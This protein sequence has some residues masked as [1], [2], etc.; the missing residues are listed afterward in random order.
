MKNLEK[1]WKLSAPQLWEI[2]RDLMRY[3]QKCEIQDKMAGELWNGLTIEEIGEKL[4]YD[5][6]IDAYF[7]KYDF[8]MV[9]EEFFDYDIL[10][11]II[12]KEVNYLDR[13]TQCCEVV[14]VANSNCLYVEDRCYC[15]KC[16]E[17]YTIFDETANE[18]KE[19]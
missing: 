8:Y 4:D 9:T 2:F 11:D 10:K 12:K 7:E 16:R 15:A 13:C 1:K 19:V 6:I 14:N 3:N 17:Q 18:W 5:A